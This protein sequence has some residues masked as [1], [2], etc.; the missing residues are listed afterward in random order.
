M[1]NSPLITSP[2]FAQDSGRPS[3]PVAPSVQSENIPRVLK[4]HR[5]WVVWRYSFSDNR[6][7][8][9]KVPY[10]VSGQKAS[11][12]DFATWTDYQTAL[13]ALSRKVFDT[14]QFDGIGFVLTKQDPFC[15]VD[16]DHCLENGV[17]N[18]WAQ[19]VVDTLA[20]YT[21]ITPSGEG[22]RIFVNARL[23]GG[24][25]KNEKIEIYDDVRFLTVTGRVYDNAAE[26]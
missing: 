10:Q 23:V 16:L 17:A 6:G 24:G 15:G 25:R 12:K 21:E 20:S 1:N 14:A 7:K 2:S 9:T 8:W 4:R 26:D 5:Q 3:R 22:L 11:T 18:A 13:A 19:H